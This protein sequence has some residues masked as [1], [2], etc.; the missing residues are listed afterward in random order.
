[1][2]TAEL[3]IDAVV[4][5]GAGLARE[6]SGRVVF[7]DGALPGE[8]VVVELVE[9][10][11]D[12]ARGALRS[13]VEASPVRVEPPCRFVGAGCGGCGWQHI[14]HDA[15]LRFKEQIVAD[16]LRRGAGLD[17]L[18]AVRTSHPMVGG[19]RTTA[20]MGVLDGR[21]AFHKRA[22]DDLVG[23]EHCMVS[24]P[25]LSELIAVGRF[26]G[27]TE[28]L[29]RTSVATGAS[30]VLAA[31]SPAGISVPA[32]VAVGGPGD[33]PSIEE[34]IAGHRFRVSGAVFFQP[35]PAVATA[36]VEAV[37]AA[38]GDL[39]GARVVDAYGG[40]GVFAGAVAVAG[41]AAAVT[42][43]EDDQDAIGDARHNLG[44][45]AHVIACEVGRWRP[46]PADV[47]IADPARPGLGKPGVG[48]LVAAH[49]GVL[50]LVSC[51]PAS[52]ARD[53]RLLGHAGY[54]AESVGLVDAFPHTPHIEAVT[55]LVRRA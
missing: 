12:F 16:A 35:S 21:A 48:A 30:L 27:A 47:V 42:V 13:I 17:E 2:T 20:R 26:E 46:S 11:K 18:P 41:G 25:R 55:R 24:H 3:Q 4:A 38:A 7:V 50:V 29:L 31:P 54:H 23:I 8:R 36:L 44:A 22:S 19:A 40:V 28:V 49:P 39:A 10:R 43:I 34:D 9:E 37:R 33:R 15:Q 52:L 6:E 14:T 5:G 51:D 32:G 1:M 53:I 45:E